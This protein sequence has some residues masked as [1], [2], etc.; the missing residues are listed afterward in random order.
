[1]RRDRI[2]YADGTVLAL[3]IIARA[4][5]GTWTREFGRTAAQ[6]VAVPAGELTSSLFQ[7]WFSAAVAQGDREWMT[8]LLGRMLAGRPPVPAGQVE[9][10]RLARHADPGLGAPGALPGPAPEA[11][12]AVREAVEILRFRY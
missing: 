11:P 2:A 1:M 6:I 4:P 10:R 5:L 12:P 7:R 8:A 3:E 9:L